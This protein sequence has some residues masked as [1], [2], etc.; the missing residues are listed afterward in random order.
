MKACARVYLCR[1]Y[2]IDKEIIHRVRPALTQ[3]LYIR[4]LSNG[5]AREYQIETLTFKTVWTFEL[6]E[7][8]S[9][10][11]ISSFFFKSKHKMG[12]VKVIEKYFFRNRNI[13]IF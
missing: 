10:R 4:E 13:S 9:S 8:N 1:T 3:I 11:N 6:S 2:S 7:F 12:M 5:A